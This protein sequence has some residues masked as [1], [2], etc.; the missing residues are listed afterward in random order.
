MLKGVGLGLEESLCLSQ[1]GGGG[2]VRAG[3][4]YTLCLRLT[5]YEAVSSILVCTGSV[6]LFGEDD[7]LG[8]QGW[9]LLN[10]DAEI[11]ARRS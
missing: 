9:F 4:D 6:A 5:E 8:S 2:G 1:G 3:T 7:V 11:M 10:T